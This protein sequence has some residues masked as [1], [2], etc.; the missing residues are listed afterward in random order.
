MWL[1][2]WYTISLF[3]VPKIVHH[4]WFS[5]WNRTVWAYNFVVLIVYSLSLYLTSLIVFFPFVYS[6]CTYLQQQQNKLQPSDRLP[7][8]EN[9]R[10]RRCKYM[11]FE[12]VKCKHVVCTKA[13]RNWMRWQI[14][15]CVCVLLKFRNSLYCLSL[16]WFLHVYPAHAHHGP[17]FSVNTKPDDG[18]PPTLQPLL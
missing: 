14:Y 15:R 4:D 10:K 8:R 9:R 7:T 12:H 3:L 5:T 18:V 2:K 16:G 1:C 11:G 17:D 6:K 13:H